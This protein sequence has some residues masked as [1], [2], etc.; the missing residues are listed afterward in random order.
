[1][2]K[3]NSIILNHYVIREKEVVKKKNIMNRVEIVGNFI[4]NNFEV[5]KLLQVITVII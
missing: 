1:M 3:N 5:K 2:E 4:N